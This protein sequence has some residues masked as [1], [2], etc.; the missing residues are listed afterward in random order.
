M[1]VDFLRIL[2]YAFLAAWIFCPTAVANMTPP[3]V[4]GKVPIDGGRKWSDGRRILGDGKTWEGLISAPATGMMVGIVQMLIAYFLDWPFWNIFGE[5]P[6]YIVVLFCLSFGAV[7]GDALGSFIK[8]RLNIGRGKKAIG[9]DQYDLVGGTFI[10]LVL[11]YFFTDG[12]VY[13]AFIYNGTFYPIVTLVALVVCEPLVHFGIN[14]IGYKI[15]TKDVP[16]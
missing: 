9:L 16:W 5:F 8:R 15:G 14:V 12:F 3:I 2:Y 11:A 1:E 4:R 13:T 7:F 6:Y 10:L